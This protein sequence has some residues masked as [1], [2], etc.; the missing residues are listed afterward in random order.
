MNLVFTTFAVYV[1]KKSHRTKQP[2]LCAVATFILAPIG[3]IPNIDL[4]LGSSP[5]PSASLTLLTALVDPRKETK[6]HE[7][8]TVSRSL[9]A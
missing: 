2:W 4:K 6:T 8:S 7:I 1:N 9:L 5:V 3:F